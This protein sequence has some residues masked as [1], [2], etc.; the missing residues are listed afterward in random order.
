MKNLHKNL[1]TALAFG[2][3]ISFGFDARAQYPA[4][5]VLLA[6]NNLDNY[7]I[8]STDD[9]YRI[10]GQIKG[11]GETLRAAHEKYPNLKS[12]PVYNEEQIVAFI[13]TG[14]TNTKHADQISNSLMQLEVLAHAV[15]SMDE[16]Y[17]PSMK[18]SKLSKVSKKDAIK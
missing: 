8:K 5:S 13:I 9:Y 15:H 18:A 2:I 1:L 16:S 3:A 11:L 4:A 6:N 12:T 7:S 10:E 17:L 14:V